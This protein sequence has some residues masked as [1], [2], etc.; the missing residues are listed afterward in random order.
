MNT[1]RI[2]AVVVLSLF[3]LAVVGCGTNKTEAPKWPS[4]PISLIVFSAAGGGTDL[5]N[6]A[7]AAAMEKDLG[8]ISVVNMPGGSGGVA[9]NHVFSREKDGYNWLGMS[10]G[11]LPVAVLGAHPTTSKDWEYFMLGG[12]PGVISVRADSPFQSVEDV[13]K[14]MKEKPGQV[15]LAAS[16]AGCIWHIKAIL[17]G[18][19][20]K[21]EY[22]FM[23]Y[24]GSNPSILAALSGE[25]DVVI[26]GLGEQAEFL[27]AKKLRPLAMVEL[28]DYDKVPGWGKVPAIV[29][30]VPDMKKHLPVDQF[31]GFALPANTPKEI[32]GKVEAS[33]KKAVQSEDVKK[34]AETK[35]VKISGLS[36]KEAKAVAEKME[37]I[38]SWALWDLKMATKSPEEFKIPRP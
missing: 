29:K 20:A 3:L 23:P 31:V 32:L 7:L 19:A 10:E 15:K 18:Q 28:E 38:F 6:R 30:T 25:I 1:Q 26:T 17:L 5:A 21:V 37:R 2:I 36:G 8:K 9:A 4:G 11:I 24:Q 16:Q 22:K 27:A 33:F 12:T 13:L 35:Y 34:Y 14:A